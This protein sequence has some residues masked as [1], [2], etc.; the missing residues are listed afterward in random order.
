MTRT[1][2]A[3][4][5]ITVCVAVVVLVGVFPS[6]AVA[7]P[8]AGRQATQERLH[9]RRCGGHAECARLRVPLDD[10][11]P[12][13]PTIRLALARVRAR[14]PKRRIGSLVVNPGGP[15]VSGVDFA[16]DA[17]SVL[18]RAIRDRFDIVGFDPRGV[19]RSAP[20]DCTERLDPYYALDFAPADDTT[21]AALVEG[22]RAL[23]KQCEKRDGRLLPYVSTRRSARDLDRIRAALGEGKLT[24]LG[25][26]YGTY[27]G[28][29][30]ADQFPSHVRAFVLD[31]PV[32]PGLDASDTQVEQAVGFEHALQLFLDDCAKRRS[33]A[34]HRGGDPAGAYDRLRARVA[35][36][37]LPAHGAGGGRTLNGTT[38]DIGVTQLLYDGHDGWPTLAH[39]LEAAYDGDGSNL[40][41]DSD[42]YTGRSDNGRYDDI[43]EAFLAI[44]C[45]DG[46]DVGGLDGLRVIEER[47]AQ[48]AP[49][50]GRTIVNSSLPCAMWPV[51]AQP[52]PVPHAAGAAPILV[53]G[54][55]D[56]PATPITWAHGLASELESATLVTVRGERH[57]AFAAGNECVDALVTRY[58]VHL[59]VPRGGT[60]C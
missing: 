23:V 45:L 6:A 14:D 55:R 15:G 56:D 25:Y 17:A 37:P 42:L 28:A 51:P 20:V 40:L 49:R 8:A 31:G 18:P 4:R 60:G 33:C 46:P 54:T 7:R 43:Q 44:G 12:G 10:A 39:D 29:S 52:A 59:D 58:L 30:Y 27:L 16:L 47:A 2:R 24:Y 36:A 26:S 9:W 53:L 21:R 32:D 34:F 35:R 1:G 48:E 13:G 22:N 19:G 11:V 41:A 57:T 50:L 5:A 38:F 3:R